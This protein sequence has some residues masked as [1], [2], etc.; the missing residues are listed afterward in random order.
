MRRTCP[1]RLHQGRNV[2]SSTCRRPYTLP[3]TTACREAEHHKSARALHELSSP[4]EDAAAPPR[5]RS[6]LCVENPQLSADV[7]ACFVA[8]APFSSCPAPE[9]QRPRCSEQQLHSTGRSLLAPSASILRHDT[10]TADTCRQGFPFLRSLLYVPLMSLVEISSIRL[11]NT[12]SCSTFE[13]K[14]RPPQ[15]LLRFGLQQVAQILTSHTR[16]CVGKVL[17]SIMK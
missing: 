8:L 6:S 5:S 15:A 16:L 2:S 12:F 7:R 1:A 10:A 9:I 14:Q 4:P 11:Q 17:V 3:S 13:A